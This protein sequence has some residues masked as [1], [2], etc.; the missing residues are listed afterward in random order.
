M[1]R[2][3]LRTCAPTAPD[4]SAKIFFENSDRG[5]KDFSIS[6]M[7][8]GSKYMVAAS[9]ILMRCEG[10]IPLLL[11]AGFAAL[12]PYHHGPAW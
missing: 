12:P 7:Q 6:N 10:F 2:K 5:N 4:E 1:V 8:G 3:K 9:Y 11:S